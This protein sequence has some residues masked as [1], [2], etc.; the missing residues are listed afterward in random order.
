MFFFAP[1]A[2]IYC[3]H[4]AT[5]FVTSYYSTGA[6]FAAPMS[7]R[8]PLIRVPCRAARTASIPCR[9]MLRVCQRPRAPDRYLRH[10]LAQRVCGKVGGRGAAGV[11]W[12]AAAV[13]RAGTAPASQNGGMAVYGGREPDQHNHVAARAQ[14]QTCATRS[15]RQRKGERRQYRS[16]AGR[17]QQQRCW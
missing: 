9:E 14:G 13:V 17:R 12:S 15:S 11:R 1:D 16:I 8:A 3:L 10:C 7:R 6:Y 2:A 5:V 4:Y